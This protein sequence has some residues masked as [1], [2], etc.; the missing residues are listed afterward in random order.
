M[1]IE[2]LKKI[3]NYIR[4]LVILSTT[5]AGSGHPGGSLSS[6]DIITALY[7][8]KLRHNPKNPKWDERDRFVL[9]KGHSVPALYSALSLCGY[10]KIEELK[11]LRKF[12]SILQGHPDALRVPGIEASTGSLGQGLSIGVGIALAAKL[13]NKDY[14]TYVL[15][16]DG[17]CDEGQIWEAFMAGNHFA[18]KGRLGNLIAIID[19]NNLQIDGNTEDVMMLNPLAERINAYGWETI[20]IDGHNFEEIIR[21]LDKK[22]SQPRAIILNTIKGKGVKFMENKAKWHGNAPN[23]FQCILG[24][25]DLNFI[26]ENDNYDYEIY[27]IAEEC[28]RKIEKK[29]EVDKESKEKCEKYCY[30]KFDEISNDAKIFVNK[31]FNFP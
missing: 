27:K 30:K 24:L 10:F 5:F 4:G 6:A 31:I 9:S 14:K 21:A 18:K 20:T 13:D 3:S 23:F 2:N 1:N 11:N 29:E 12:G 19:R 28:Q 25:K 22:Y 7:F 17:E 8:Y 26:N 15:T 16:G